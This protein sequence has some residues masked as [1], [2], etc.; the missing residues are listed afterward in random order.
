[1]LTVRVTAVGTLTFYRLEQ[2]LHI[3]A[4]TDVILG[5]KV[6]LSLLLGAADAVMGRLDL[7]F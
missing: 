6:D 3:I 1:M 2:V 4:E 7:L 5:P